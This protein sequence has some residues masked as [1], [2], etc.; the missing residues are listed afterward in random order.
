MLVSTVFV[1]ICISAFACIAVGYAV[2]AVSSVPLSVAL[3]A[4]LL[5]MLFA[6]CVLFVVI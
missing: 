3:L 4:L 2:R 1:V 5:M 6:L